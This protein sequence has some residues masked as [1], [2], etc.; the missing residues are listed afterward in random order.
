[1]D[2]DSMVTETG[3]ATFD[4]VIHDSRETSLVCN[5]DIKV[6]ILPSDDEYM[7]LT[8]HLKAL[9]DPGIFSTHGP[10]LCCVQKCGE[11]KCLYARILTVSDKRRSRHIFDK[12]AI[13]DEARAIGL[14]MSNRH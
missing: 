9:K 1:M 6:V 4:N 13:T 3:I 8:F 7:T 5:I 11:N 12:D 14:L 2:W 10:C